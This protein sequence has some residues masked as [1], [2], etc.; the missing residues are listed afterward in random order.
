MQVTLHNQKGETVGKA[1]LPKELFE[2]AMNPDLV[3]QVAVTQ[4]ANRRQGTT[5]T[6]NRGEVRGGGRKPWR[7]KGTG[8]ARHGSIR[9]PQWRHGG[10]VFGPRK[11]KVYGGKINKKMKQKARAMVLSA[12]AAN[13]MI[14][15]LDRLEID[16][17]KTKSMV[18][19]LE[20]IKKANDNF[21][22]GSVL[23]AT[24]EYDKNIMLASRNLANAAVIEAAKLNVLDLLNSKC[25]LMPQTA[26]AALTRNK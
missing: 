8:R 9:A 22:K 2:V 20:N 1:K 25:L 15:V 7:Q 6:K 4:A 19:V 3:Y 12:K 16:E 24:P 18:Q 5:H 11:D 17:P 13:N 14:V 10:V 23:I 26:I 21:K